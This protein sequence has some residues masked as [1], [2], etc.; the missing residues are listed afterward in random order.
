M[1]GLGAAIRPALTGLRDELAGAGIPAS[2]NPGEVRTPG[3][4]V[5]ARDIPLDSLT[6]AGHGSLRARI[7]LVA[8]DVGALQAWDVLGELL[9][10]A[11]TVIGPDSDI[12]L[13]QAIT[14]PHTPSTPLPAFRLDVDLPL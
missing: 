14:L 5:T 10:Q 1:P 9:D 4:W 12:A 7:W 2:L 8:P 3:A 11:L 6:L 13:N